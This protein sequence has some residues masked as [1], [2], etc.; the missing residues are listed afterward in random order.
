MLR[1]TSHCISI[2]STIDW[3]I[4]YRRYE[5]R[6]MKKNTMNQSILKKK[7]YLWV[8]LALFLLSLSLHWIFGYEA[9][10]N[11]QAEH[12]QEIV[13]ADYL[14]EMMRDTMENWQ[15]EF[16]Q[17]IWQVAGLSFLW[18]VGSPDSKEGDD[19]KE[20]KL[21]YILKKIDPDNYSK[22]MK[23]WEEKYPKE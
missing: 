19:R 18:Y 6:S 21:D 5:K 16:L 4:F 13:M 20:E 22:M 1:F 7:G 11:E 3:H 23:E 15:S 12:G 8:T 10:K 9:F 14:V 17:L 2:L